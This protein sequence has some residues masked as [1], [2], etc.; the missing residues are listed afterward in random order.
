MSIAVP[1]PAEKLQ[2]ATLANKTRYLE[3]CAKI[4]G[5]GGTDPRA[6][7]KRAL[8]L[9]PDVIYFLTDGVFKDDVA[10]EVTKL[11][12]RGVSIHTFCFGDAAGEALLKSI[13]QRNSG[14]YKFIP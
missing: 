3:W 2:P 14:T 8:E 6:A 12:T 5:G 13:A 4:R 1:M 7:L 10:G 11:N 9:G